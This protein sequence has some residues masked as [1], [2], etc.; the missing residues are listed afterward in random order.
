MR[1]RGG[2]DGPRAPVLLA[3]AALGTG[4]WNFPMLAVWDSGGTVLGLP[5]LPVAL[6]A[7]WAGLIAALAWVSERGE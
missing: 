3:L 6:F 1:P 4:L 7:V 5:A 2:R